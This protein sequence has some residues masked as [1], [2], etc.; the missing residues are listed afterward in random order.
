[1]FYKSTF[2]AFNI[3]YPSYS[4][5]ECLFSSFKSPSNFTFVIALI[6]RPPTSPLPL[7]LEEFSVLTETL[8][9]FLLFFLILGDFNISHNNKLN[10]YSLKLDYIFDLFNLTQHDHFPTHTAGNTL[11]YIISSSFTKPSISAE[12]VPFSDHSLINHSFTIPSFPVVHFKINKRLW[13]TFNK[14]S[15]IIF[16]SQ[17]SFD[18]LSFSDPNLFLTASNDPLLKVLM[19]FP[20]KDILFSPYFF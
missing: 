5:F 18:L 15:F 4:S 2:S 19:L 1:M 10:P 12:S 11:D 20:Y 9:A 16:F 14:D 13:S 17:S 3:H 6:D 8:Y 7:F